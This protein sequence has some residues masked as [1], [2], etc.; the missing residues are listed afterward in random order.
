MKRRTGK[1]AT[2]KSKS[3]R[4]IE[5]K[6]YHARKYL[7][8]AESETLYMKGEVWRLNIT[9]KSKAGCLW[10]AGFQ[11]TIRNLKVHGFQHSNN[12]YFL[13]KACVSNQDHHK[14]C[15]QSSL[16][17]CLTPRIEWHSE[18]RLGLFSRDVFDLLIVSKN[19]TSAMGSA[20]LISRVS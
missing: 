19:A 6:G 18:V 3:T 5:P 10:P 13:H 9:L 8:S 16:A 11:N 20:P 4:G 12:H 7:K 2:Q 15:Q 17:Q 1:E 14:P